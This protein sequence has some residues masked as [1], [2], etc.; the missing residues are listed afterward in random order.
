MIGQASGNAVIAKIKAMYGK[1]LHSND[2]EELLRK[3]SVVEVATYLKS[4]TN[5]NNILKN[6]NETTIHR[7]QLEHLLS[8][9]IFQSYIKL[10]RFLASANKD[11]FKFLIVRSEI[12]E[13]L[14]LITLL[15]AKSSETFIIDLPAYLIKHSSFDLLSLANVRNFDDLLK[16]IEKTP[17]HN[18][19]EK[20]RPK[21][22]LIDYTKSERDL[23][24]YYYEYMFK[25][26]EKSFKGS[27]KQKLIKM[28]KFEAELFN[29]M[30]IYRLK[31]FFNYSN[32]K[33]SEMILP[34]HYKLNKNKLNQ[35]LA[36][37]TSDD[38]VEN[39]IKQ[40]FAH[41]IKSK[42]FNYIE[43]YA[44]TVKYYNNRFLL[45]F[46]TSAPEIFFVYFGLR[47]REL[48]NLINIIEGVRYNIDTESIRKLIIL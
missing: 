20:N 1:R 44:D 10:S 34:I 31:I 33:I 41:K 21:N 8:R 12:S 24:I 43:N 25:A 14:R 2:Y 16:V 38:F 3:K 27:Q 7:G 15:N 30:S 18:I 42:E 22:E 26:V 4:S 6:I 13:I 5:Y 46:S 35:L 36:N 29:I 23:Y 47:Y 28:L 17:Y 39:Y 32:Q 48:S 19:M 11:F 9:D 45:R 37:A 40:N